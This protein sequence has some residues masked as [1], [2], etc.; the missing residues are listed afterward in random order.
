MIFPFERGGA[1]LRKSKLRQE[2]LNEDLIAYNPKRWGVNIPFRDY[3]F[4]VEDV[5]PALSGA[6][7]KVSL[8]AAFAV[9]WATGLNI[10]DPAFVT[11]NVRLEIMLASIFTILFCAILNPYVGPPGTLAPLIPA[12]SIMVSAEVHPL[13][14]SILIGLIGIGISVFRYFS[15]V[16]DINGAGTKGGI[17]LLFG[18]LGITSS[19]ENLKN[20]TEKNE[21]PEML[22]LLLISGLVLYTLLNKYNAR[23]VIIP[24]CAAA[25]IAISSSFGL[26]PELK[27][28]IALPIIDPN[29][30]WNEKWGIGWGLNARNFIKALP[31]ALLAVVMWP[32]DALAVKTIQETNYPERAKRAV[33]D[34]NST[35]FVVSLRNIAGALLGGGQI[36][37]IWRSFMIP[38][39][40][41]KRP[42]G[43]SALILGIIGASFGVLG[44][45]IDIAVF[46]PLLWLVLIFGVYIPLMEVGLTTIKT[47]ASAQ[48][49]S[50]CI[51]AGIAVN[52]V[53][54]WVAS[55]FIENFN[56][57]KDSKADRVLTPKELYI[58]AGLVIITL[59]TL[60]SAYLL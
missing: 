10:T 36:S 54:G 31:F 30:W 26:Y 47:V 41:V 42:I 21:A 34:M 43:A 4:R 13:P 11:E 38:L 46:P 14:L 27:T 28:G 45:P 3:S 23:W 1:G 60:L 29:T 39:G 24:A 6:I 48:A 32:L 8:V 52:P 22:V 9:A 40:V 18:L 20:W 2:L 35:Y 51:I 37:A 53:L 58:T 49:A 56:I 12:V 5:I 15:K 59:I 17:I 55:V 16:V 7:G 19:Y 50:V 44:A 33:F 57:I 25:A